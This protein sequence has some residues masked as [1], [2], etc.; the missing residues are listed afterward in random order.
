MSGLASCGRGVLRRS[1]S[2]SGVVGEVARQLAEQCEGATAPCSATDDS[3]PIILQDLLTD[4]RSLDLAVKRMEYA[5]KDANRMMENLGTIVKSI[6]ANQGQGPELSETQRQTSFTH[7]RSSLPDSPIYDAYKSELAATRQPKGDQA[8]QSEAACCEQ[9]SCAEASIRAQLEE[10][11]SSNR[12]M[13]RALAAVQVHARRSLLMTRRSNHSAR[14]ICAC[15][16]LISPPRPSKLTRHRAASPPLAAAAAVGGAGARRAA[17]RARL[18]PSQGPR[19]NRRPRPA[20]PRR[21][22]RGP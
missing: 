5:H 13:Q 9:G 17:R 4:L 20:R 3:K 8:G 10:A 21:K 1:V 6:P 19:R 16:S 11:R 18:P 7:L 12:M 14:A 2:N 15:T 22:R